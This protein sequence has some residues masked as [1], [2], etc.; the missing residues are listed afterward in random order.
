MRGRLENRVEL[1]GYS[2]YRVIKRRPY[3]GES[4]ELGE[5]VYWK[6]PDLTQ[7]MFEDRWRPGTWLGKAE[8]SDEN[9][10]ADADG[11]H[12]ARSVQRRFKQRFGTSQKVKR[13][14]WLSVRSDAKEDDVDGAAIC[15]Q[16]HHV[17]NGREKRSLS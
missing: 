7:Q 6:V 2:K 16:M 10:I 17:G 8:R 4:V 5:Q 13:I 11:V 1:N 3:G 9:L 14:G 12:I 15:S